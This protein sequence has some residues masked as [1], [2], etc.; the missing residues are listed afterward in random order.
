VI[1]AA[2]AVVAER[3]GSSGHWG[4]PPTGREAAINELEER[5]DGAVA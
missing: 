3:T 1:A 2:V 4:R 5:L